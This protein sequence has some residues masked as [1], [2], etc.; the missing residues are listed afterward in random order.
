M[1]HLAVADEPLLFDTDT[2][3]VG[4]NNPLDIV[5]G[6]YMDE[7]LFVV[8]IVDGQVGKTIGFV[9]LS[10]IVE[11]AYMILF[12]VAHAGFERHAPVVHPVYQQ[13]TVAVAVGYF[14][15]DDVVPQHHAHPHADQDHRGHQQVE[16]PTHEQ[17]PFR[18]HE[19]EH[20]RSQQRNLH[21]GGRHEPPQLP[22]GGVTDD[23]PVDAEEVE[24]QPADRNRQQSYL[25]HGHH[26]RTAG[27]EMPR[28]QTGQERTQHRGHRIQYQH[29]PVVE[30]VHSD[31]PF[32]QFAYHIF[33]HASFS[34]SGTPGSGNRRSSPY[35]HDR[36]GLPASLIL[37][38]IH[39]IHLL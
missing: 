23:I 20:H 29:D 35:P 26:S 6:D 14:G 4:K 24:R 25:H 11:S 15:N 38:K 32:P 7:I 12:A 30:I 3:V 1:V 36:P 10:V 19:D 37:A 31:N 21:P 34:K 2:L 17:L 5:S 16:Q 8:E 18:L 9:G 13:V 33:L 28:Q 39:N 27:N 22:Q